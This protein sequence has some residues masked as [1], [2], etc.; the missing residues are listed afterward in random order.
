MGQ[1]RNSG[2]R[3]SLDDQ[4][5]RAAGREQNMPESRA[6]RDAYTE[7]PA[8]G[9]AGGAFGKAGQAHRAGA[10]RRAKDAAVT[11]PRSSRP[12]RKRSA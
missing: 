7:L 3:A 12:P 9:R 11:T 4:K 10:P 6:I 8:R 5:R 2:R 1:A